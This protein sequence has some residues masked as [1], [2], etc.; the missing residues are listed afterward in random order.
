M[1]FLAWLFRE[2]NKGSLKFGSLEASGV[3]GCCTLLGVVAL[4]AWLRPF[5]WLAQIVV[6]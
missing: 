5:S 6:G 4:M 1:K 2:L 3:L